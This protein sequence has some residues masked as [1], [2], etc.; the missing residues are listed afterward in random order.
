MTK[1][2]GGTYAFTLQSFMEFHTL[3]ITGILNSANEPI[4]KAPE[5]GKHNKTDRCQ[6]LHEKRTHGEENSLS[7]GEACFILLFVF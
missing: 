6:E 2:D 4:L 1:G 3:V 5:L 7:I